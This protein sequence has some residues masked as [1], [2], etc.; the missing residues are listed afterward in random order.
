MQKARSQWWIGIKMIVVMFDRKYNRWTCEVR[1]DV[2]G[3]DVENRRAA[4]YDCVF[5][6]CRPRVPS[7]W[8]SFVFVGLWLI[9]A[10]TLT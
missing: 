2:D 1:Q 6:A 8:T 7:K 3:I 10:L 5:S 4:R 9:T